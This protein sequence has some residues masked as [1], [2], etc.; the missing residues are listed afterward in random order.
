MDQDKAVFWFVLGKARCERTELRIWTISCMDTQKWKKKSVL[1]RFHHLVFYRPRCQIPKEDGEIVIQRE[2]I[3]VFSKRSYFFGIC[4]N[5]LDITLLRT[6]CIDPRFTSA[7]SINR[8]SI[9]QT[10]LA[11][12]VLYSS[13]LAFCFPLVLLPWSRSA[14]IRFECGVDGCNGI[15]NFI[16]AWVT[17]LALFGRNLAKRLCNNCHGL[18][19]LT[20]RIT[21]SFLSRCFPF[22]Q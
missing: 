12:C 1:T 9:D 6:F 18:V 15:F 14:A 4:A 11:T 7:G 17:I 10:Q 19:V 21:V 2:E 3:I 8:V 22:Q 20:I 5:Q 13:H 16:V